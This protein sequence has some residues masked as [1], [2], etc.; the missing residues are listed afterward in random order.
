MSTSAAED[1]GFPAAVEPSAKN[2]E[3]SRCFTGTLPASNERTGPA[4]RSRKELV[5][6]DFLTGGVSKTKNLLLLNLY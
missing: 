4:Q 6:G 5:N 1:D 2:T 3:A